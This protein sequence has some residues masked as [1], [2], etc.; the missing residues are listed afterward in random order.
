MAD[1]KAPPSLPNGSDSDVTAIPSATSPAN[2][3]T[4]RIRLLVSACLLGEEVRYD[5]GHKY[6]AFLVES[7]G[8]FVAWERVWIDDLYAAYEKLFMAT[9]AQKTTIKKVTD[10]LQHMVGYF[11]KLLTSDEKAELLET[12]DA[13]RGS[14]VPLIVP[15]TIIKHY[16]RKY[17]V[18]YLARQVFLSPFPA[19]LMLR[20]H[21]SL[22]VSAAAK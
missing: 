13:Y 21:V 12:I 6:D 4:S 9:L 17:E 18:R 19:E 3:S 5:K 11:K 14:Q 10:V 1:H 20:N 16:V 15:V 2:G 22:P 7:L 8:P